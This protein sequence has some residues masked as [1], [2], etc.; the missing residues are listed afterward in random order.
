LIC[1]IRYDGG[2]RPEDYALWV[3]L[4]RLFAGN[5]THLVG[6][7]SIS[8]RSY[9]IDEFNPLPATAGGVSRAS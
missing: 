8:R 6:F 1:P 3:E 4:R 2:P 7:V 5:P 9:W